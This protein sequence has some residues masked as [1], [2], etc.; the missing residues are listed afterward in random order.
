MAELLPHAFG[1]E[2]LEAVTGETP[3]PV[4]PARL[5]EW[6]GRGTVFVHP[7]MSAGA[8]GLDGV[9][10]AVRR[11]DAGAE[12]GVLEEG[13][14]WDDPA[15]AIAWGLARTPRVV[16]VDATGGMFWAGEG[17]P[18]LRSR[19]LVELAGGPTVPGSGRSG[20]IPPPG[21]VGPALV[22]T[23]AGRIATTRRSLMSGFAAVDVIRA[24]RD[25]GRA[26]RRADRLGGRRVHPGRGR[27]RADV[28][29]GDGDPAPR[30]DRAGDRPVDRRDDRQR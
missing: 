14:S 7:D 30:H 27:R 17:E 4:V 21:T 10:G 16:V 11:D 3:V 23:A 18:P 29:A 15:E 12:T 9:L 26:V 20:L 13:P 22:G 5:A 1:P 6:R 25:G 2:D 19:S 8:A 28:G 24:K